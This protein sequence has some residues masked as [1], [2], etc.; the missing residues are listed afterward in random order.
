MANSIGS[1]L[2]AAMAPDYNDSAED[3]VF[4]YILYQVAKDIKRS[5]FGG[6]QALTAKHVTADY[7]RLRSSLGP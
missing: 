2:G 7:C 1:I 6:N 5:H 3:N 4:P